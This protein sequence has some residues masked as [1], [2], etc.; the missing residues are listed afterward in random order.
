VR[1]RARPFSAFVDSDAFLEARGTPEKIA[2][3]CTGAG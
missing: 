3:H 1:R 2:T